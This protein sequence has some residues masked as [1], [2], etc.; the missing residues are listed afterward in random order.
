VGLPS[1]WC[2]L[3]VEVDDRHGQREAFCYDTYLKRSQGRPLSLIFECF[4]YDVTALQSLLQ[5][6]TKQIS[7]LDITCVT[8]LELL[9]QDLPAL[10]ELKVLIDTTPAHA[11]SIS[12]LAFT[13]RSLKLTGW[14]DIQNLSSFNPVW[15]HLTNVEIATCRPHVLLHLLQLGSNLSSLIVELR[16]DKATQPLEPFTHK[17]PSVVVHL[18]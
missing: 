12:R 4:K 17:K 13:L 7:S 5:P 2:R 16:N 18:F 14:S 6:Y 11:Q 1:L 8:R 9:L 10:Q 15:A 3:C